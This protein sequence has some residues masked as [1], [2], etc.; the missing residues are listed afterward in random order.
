[1]RIYKLST[2]FLFLL[3]ALNLKLCAFNLNVKNSENLKTEPLFK[4]S[5]FL[6]NCDSKNK[7]KF[8][9]IFEK[10]ALVEELHTAIKKK[11]SVIASTPLFNYLVASGYYKKT[12]KK[13]FLNKQSNWNIFGTK[14]KNFIILI[15]TCKHPE[16]KR[17]RDLEQDLENL[18]INFKKL[19]VIR[20]YNKHVSTKNLTKLFENPEKV[21]NK[22]I[23]HLRHFFL[24]EK[25]DKIQLLNVQI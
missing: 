5:V 11:K 10:I 15:P 14:D 18:G 21:R 19:C 9:N 3:V 20:I 25:L 23:K 1:M 8:D 4:A 22:D 24:K 7:S 6:D 17:A 13:L 2:I 16:I 12:I